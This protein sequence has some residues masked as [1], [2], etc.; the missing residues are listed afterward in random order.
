MTTQFVRALRA[1]VLSTVA[2]AALL[3]SAVAVPAQAAAPFTVSVTAEATGFPIAGAVV[4]GR[5]FN[6]IGGHTLTPVTTN[7][8]GIAT[9]TQVFDEYDLDIRASGFL[10][11]A[12]YVD[13][14][15]SGPTVNVILGAPTTSLNGTV[16]DEQGV[17][18]DGA[19]VQLNC[20]DGDCGYYYATTAGGGQYSFPDLGAAEY[21]VYIS[22]PGHKWTNDDLTLT[23][24]TPM[25]RDY[26]LTAEGLVEGTVTT[27]DGTPIEGINV[28]LWSKVSPDG[29]GGGVTDAD[30]NFSFGAAPGEWT[31]LYWDGP[32]FDGNSGEFRVPAYETMFLGDV[33]SV[34]ESETFQVTKGVTT[35]LDTK[36]LRLG[37]TISGHVNI[38]T[39]NG[40]INLTPGRTPGSSLYRLVEGE[41][42][43]ILIPSSNAGLGG[44]GDFTIFGVPAGT[45]RLGFVDERG[46]SPRSF[47]SQF[48]NNQSTV[49]T[50]QDIVV[51]S[52]EQVTGKNAT[53]VTPEPNFATEE[54][55]EEDFTPENEKQSMAPNEV[56]QDETIEL[57][58]GSQYAGEWVSATA[59]STPVRLGP[60]WIQVPSN[61]R[62]SVSIPDT[63]EGGEHK[64]AVQLADS[65]ILGWA[66][67]LVTEMPRVPFEA[68]TSPSIGGLPRVGITLTA[69]IPAW[70]PAATSYEYRW[71]RD[72]DTI[73][74][75]TSAT[76]TVTG[77][78]VGHELQVTI[79]GKRYGYYS[80]L[81]TS[82]PTAVV[83]AATMRIAK[84]VVSGTRAVGN[85]LTVTSSASSPVDVTLNYQWLRNSVAIPGA[86]STSYTVTALDA[87]TYVTARVVGTKL[88]YAS[89]TATS[90]K[91][92]VATKPGTIRKPTAQLSGNVLGSV[93]RVDNNQWQPSGVALAY[94]WKIGGTA[95]SGATGATYTPTNPAWRGRAL[96]VTITASKAGY[97][98]TILTVRA[99]T[100][101]TG[102]SSPR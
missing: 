2:V 71:T 55:S 4:S 43:R 94:Q 29:G 41:W 26:V 81:E 17:P 65:E 66:D 42:E 37:A 86:T 97:A 90:A 83:P 13:A 15:S 76:Y 35:T 22:K 53:V 48:W 10:R 56:Q 82:T 5:G 84:P 38:Q 28:H 27:V 89:A 8:S 91:P 16:R 50:A 52:G 49:G 96:T 60:Q 62:I 32:F 79:I 85:T 59:H 36:T 25:Q 98:T 77:A 99:V 57:V 30:G 18:V 73:V 58:L 92:S 24:G 6:F 19:T 72:Y 34:D 20:D 68:T 69:T 7:S 51:T 54:P 21:H 70:T 45:Y 1:A 100:L 101:R 80:S 44:A 75:A 47:A 67:L 63:I 14:S 46:D 88:G 3:A 23:D 61:G 95:I 9:I 74:G 87:K 78:D 102:L 31:V 40:A 12:E 93:I 11:T 39:P 33:L 64:V